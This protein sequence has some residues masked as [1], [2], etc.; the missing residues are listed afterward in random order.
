M[1]ISTY[2]EGCG[3]TFAARYDRARQCLT[4]ECVPCDYSEITITLPD[5]RAL[6]DEKQG[7]LYDLLWRTAEKTGETVPTLTYLTLSEE[8]VTV[9]AL[10]AKPLDLTPLMESFSS[11]NKWMEDMVRAFAEA[12][13]VPPSEPGAAM[14]PWKLVPRTPAVGQIHQFKPITTMFPTLQGPAAK[15]TQ[16]PWDGNPEDIDRMKMQLE[17]LRRVQ[18]KD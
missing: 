3:N 10:P 5:F 4:L 8:P 1:E 16:L 14:E 6:P 18:R 17:L 2:C 7:A 13:G 15:V 9:D 11:F 12:F